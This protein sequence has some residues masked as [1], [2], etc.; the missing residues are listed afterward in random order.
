MQ[1][2][3]ESQRHRERPEDGNNDAP[4]V[5]PRVQTLHFADVDELK[6]VELRR[7][8]TPASVSRVDH[9]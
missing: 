7:A 6:P 2:A 1:I 4:S 8:S 3:Q 5:P 9:L